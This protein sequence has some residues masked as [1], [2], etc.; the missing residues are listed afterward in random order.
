MSISK[1]KGI[2]LALASL[3]VLAFLLFVVRGQGQG[4]GGGQ[5]PPGNQPPTEVGF[6]QTIR[7]NAD[8]MLTEGKTIFRFDT[9]GDESFWSGALQLHRAIL[10]LPNG[11]GPG[12][13]P[14]AALN[15]GLKVDMDALPASLIQDIQQGRV[16]LDAPATTLALLRLNAMV[17]VMGIFDQPLTNPAQAESR[18]ALRSVGITCALCHSTVDNAFA[19]GIGHRL[20]GWANRDLNVGAIIALSP[21][22]T[23]LADVLGVGV[24]TVRTVVNSWGPG[25]FDAELILD[26][27][28]FRPDGKSAAT[29]LPPAFGLA[30]VNLHTWTGAWGGVTYWNAF[31]A[32]LEM[33]GKG[34]FFDP[35]LNDAAQFP[36]AAR[37]GFGNVRNSPDLITPKLAAL[38]FYQL[39]IPAPSGLSAVPG[40]TTPPGGPP[41]APGTPPAPGTGVTLPPN[42]PLNQAAVARGESLF[43]GK[44]QCATCHVPP[45][46]TEPGWNL[47][48]PAEIGID[49]F[50]AN[51][52]PDKR[53]RTAPLRGLWTHQK[54]G[55]YHDGRFATLR[56][57]IDHY[58]TF[59]SL[60]LTEQEKND[61]AAYLLSL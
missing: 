53:Y 47:H 28:G 45:L 12:L 46:F 14:R 61:L 27:K 39:A 10:G 8:Q 5:N 34:T 3:P 55:F 4:Q 6:S 16:D 42:V 35:R 37:N 32:N 51:R 58:N 56:D 19:E 23:P 50:Q 59:K 33:Q 22:L 44:A 60:A 1:S 7:Q 40:A 11:V 25:K 31:V 29:L 15:L 52:S 26:G 13:S 41:A 18:G 21:N 9:F 54:G 43:K 17:G 57:V 20:D 38:H 24:E 30:G 36:V 49:D 2:P 48:T